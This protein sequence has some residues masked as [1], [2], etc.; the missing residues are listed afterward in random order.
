MPQWVAGAPG[1]IEALQQVLGATG[2]YRGAMGGTRVLWGYQGSMGASGVLWGV[3]GCYG[4]TEALT[5][6]G[7]AEALLFLLLGATAA[8]QEPGWL[9]VTPSRPPAPAGATGVAAG[10]PGPPGPPEAAGLLVPSGPAVPHPVA[11]LWHHC[12][13]VGHQW[14]GG[15]PQGSAGGC[16]PTSYLLEGDALPSA[17]GELSTGTPCPVGAAS[18]DVALCREDMVAT[19]RWPWWCDH[20]GVTTVG[21]SR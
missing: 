1:G 21:R 10:L 11:H 15:S 19:V 6:A 20:G 4:G 16:P 9:L 17:A 7:A 3:L 14:G 5:R 12:E 13:P 2:E 18:G 8:A